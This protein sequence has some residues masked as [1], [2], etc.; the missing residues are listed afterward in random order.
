MMGP[1]MSRS[2]RSLGSRRSL[3]QLRGDGEDESVLAVIRN[4]RLFPQQG[5]L[6][7]VVGAAVVKPHFHI[8]KSF[9][10][11]KHDFKA[12]PIYH[13]KRESIAHT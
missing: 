11:S 6:L 5:D 13:N 12:R 3:E 10:M 7:G 2:T 4:T 9:R 8:E 1:P